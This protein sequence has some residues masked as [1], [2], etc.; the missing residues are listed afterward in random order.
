MKYFF[1]LNCCF[2]FFLNCISDKHSGSPTDQANS[3]KPYISFIVDSFRSYSFDSFNLSSFLFSPVIDQDHIWLFGGGKVYD[4][5]LLHNEK[6]LIE[7]KYPG[8]NL[9]NVQPKDIWKD[10]LRNEIFITPYSGEM[11]RYDIDK[12]LFT[13]Y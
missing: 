8:L 2:L 5:D 6:M 7:K 9:F 10:T 11:I 3:N 13:K 12:G 1:W 4:V